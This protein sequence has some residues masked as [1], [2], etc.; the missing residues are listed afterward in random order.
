MKNLSFLFLSV[1][2]F[3]N[4]TKSELVQ[5]TKVDSDQTLRTVSFLDYGSM[6]NEALDVIYIQFES[7]SFEEYTENELLDEAYSQLMT[8]LIDTL[9]LAQDSINDLLD[10]LDLP[11]NYSTIMSGWDIDIYDSLILELGNDEIAT[12]LNEILLAL[13][14]STNYSNFDSRL[15]SI[16][17]DINGALYEADILQITSIGRASYL[18]WESNISKWET[19]GGGSN[20]L[21][22]Q[23]ARIIAADIRAG[24]LGV[25]GYI[26]FATNPWAI[27]VLAALNSGL[28]GAIISIEKN[29]S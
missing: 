10:S 7:M 15:L 16:E 17:Q 1:L 21:S 3:A 5:S 26:I 6:H 18:Y 19:V 11:H 4:C 2:L 14:Q 25:V 22:Q 29:Q 27:L 12:V 20:K 8:Y 24:C 23:A 13:D 28:E 9:Y